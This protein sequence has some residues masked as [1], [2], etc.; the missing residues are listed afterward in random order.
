MKQPAGRQ[1]LVWYGRGVHIIGDVLIIDILCIVVFIYDIYIYAYI[2]SYSM[3]QTVYIHIFFEMFSSIYTLYART[4]MSI[5]VDKGPVPAIHRGV[6]HE[7]SKNDPT[8]N[9]TYDLF[10]E[11][12]EDFQDVLRR[13]K[14]KWKYIFLSCATISRSAALRNC[15][16]FLIRWKTQSVS[17]TSPARSWETWLPSIQDIRRPSHSSHVQ[18]IFKSFVQCRN[19]S[20]KRENTQR[21]TLLIISGGV[22][23]RTLTGWSHV[24][25]VPT[26]QGPLCDIGVQPLCLSR[27][28]MEKAKMKKY[29]WVEL[30]CNSCFTL[31]SKKVWE[32]SGMY[33][34]PICS[35]ISFRWIIFLE[36]NV[37][38]TN[39]QKKWGMTVVTQA[40]LSI[41]S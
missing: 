7:N 28:F 27:G 32:Y 5:Y 15:G 1:L 21:A 23:P 37:W 9:A 31:F 22:S 10:H 18:F 40:W 14:T 38:W 34:Y 13:K 26:C 25:S 20:E 16:W 39:P 3:Y 35:S 41:W 12:L 24:F 2:H 19:P 8:E 17:S 29:G 36:Q 33:M 6:F 4:L 30:G 11:R